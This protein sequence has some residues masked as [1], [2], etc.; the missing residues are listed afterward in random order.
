MS[1]DAGT[2]VGPYK[3]LGEL[4]EGAMG[5]VFRAQDPRLHREVAI[6]MLP[7]IFADDPSRMERFE[8]EV[9]AVGML[10][11]PRAIPLCV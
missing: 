7:A 3:I 5:Q 2:Q 11:H 6:K 1:W 8:R 4:G 10:N 9:K